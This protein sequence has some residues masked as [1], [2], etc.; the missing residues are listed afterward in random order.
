MQLLTNDAHLHPRLHTRHTVSS[1][2]LKKSF[3]FQPEL[4]LPSSACRWAS[5]W[6]QQCIFYLRTLLPT[7]NIIIPQTQHFRRSQETIW[8]K[9]PPPPTLPEERSRRGESVIDLIR[10]FSNK[11]TENNF[12]SAE[13]RPSFIYFYF[14]RGVTF[15]KSNT[16]LW[17]VAL[18]Q[19]AS[20]PAIYRSSHFSAAPQTAR[21]R[22]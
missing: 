15:E 11:P 3:Q 18:S 4:I 7:Q 2:V 14:F 5:G 21:L 20:Q 17:G 1:V 8:P 6:R 12:T 10:H 19:P 16:Q 9:A 22:L 13:L